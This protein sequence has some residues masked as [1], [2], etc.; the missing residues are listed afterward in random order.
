M[1][2]AIVTAYYLPIPTPRAFRAT[3]LAQEFARRG[4]SVTVYNSITDEGFEYS[5]LPT[6]NNHLRY[7]NLDILNA[8]KLSNSNSNKRSKFILFLLSNIRLLTYY[9]TTNKW[10]LLYK[11]LKKNLHFDE[12]YDLLISI[13]LPFHIHWGVG[14]LIDKRNIS[15]CYVADYG[16]PFSK[17]NPSIKVAPY[18]RFIERKIISK[19]DYIT[20]PTEIALNSYVW[21]K[22]KS[23]IKVIPQ[24]FDFSQIVIANY[25]PNKIPTFAYAGLF[26]SD[27]RNP[28][29]FFKFLCELECDFRFYIYTNVGS[30][31]NLS[32]IQPFISILK[33]KLI[34]KDIIPRLSLIEELSKLDFI[35]NINNISSNQIPSK[36]IDYTLSQRPIFSLSQNEF[37]DLKFMKFM[38]GNYI[39]GEAV[40]LDEFS[41]KNVADK[42]EKLVRNE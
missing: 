24:G 19:F 31:D 34:I 5:S 10:F 15:D 20:V 14:R 37:D 28:K 39:N 21:L 30:M 6:Y 27:I 32:C 18:F 41:I 35:I 38:N 42:F 40:D 13:G 2:I 17:H 22:D 8:E 29:N 12:H 23:K 11:G 36:L 26:Y 4:H 33:E 9:F 7:I 1:K 3:E 25:K 16:D